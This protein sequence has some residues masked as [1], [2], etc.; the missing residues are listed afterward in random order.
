MSKETDNKPTPKPSAKDQREARMKAAL[1]ANLQK[2]KA[3]WRA[4]KSAEPPQDG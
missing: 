2:R 1:R 4:R 3:Q